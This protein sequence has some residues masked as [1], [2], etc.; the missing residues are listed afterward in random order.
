MSAIPSPTNS[1]HTGVAMA[2]RLSSSWLYAVVCV[3]GVFLRIVPAYGQ[4]NVYPPAPQTESRIANR[5]TDDASVLDPQPGNWVEGEITGN[6]VK[7]Y[8]VA[9]KSNEYLE[10][11]VDQESVDMA[12]AVISGEGRW[13]FE[14]D[15]RE[16]GPEPV[17]LVAEVEGVY[18]LEIR[19][20]RPVSRPEPYK[21]RIKELRQATPQDS[22]RVAAEAAATEGKRLL[23]EGTADFLKQAREKYNS[24]LSLWQV[25]GD[26]LGEADALHSLGHI[27]NILGDSQQALGQLNAALELRRASGDRYGEGETLHNIA[28]A[29]SGWGDKKKAIEYYQQALSLRRSVGD[30]KGEAYDLSNLGVVYRSLGDTR[31]ALAYSTEALPLW[32]ELGDRQG[33]AMV[34]NTLGSTYR[35]MGENQKALDSFRQGLVLSRSVN[36]HRGEAYMLA[37]LSRVYDDLGEGEEA[38]SSYNQAL[39]LM[40]LVGDLRGEADLLADVAGLYDATGE[41][42]EAGDYYRRALALSEVTHDRRA[43]GYVLAGLGRIDQQLGRSAEAI[44]LEHQAL[45]LMQSVGDLRGQAVALKNLGTFYD[46]QGERQQAL[47]FFRQT[48]P[49]WQAVQDKNGECD[50]LFRIARVEQDVGNLEE[51]RTEIEAALGMIESLRTKVVSQELRASYFASKQSLYEFYINLLMRLHRLH[52]SEGFDATA[53]ETNERA[54]ARTLLETLEEAGADIRQGADPLLLEHERGLQQRINAQAQ[55]QTRL[56]SGKYT[57]AQAREAKD[58]LNS[59]LAE[60]REVQAEI[61]VK[62]PRYAALTQPHPLGLREIQ[63]ELL[64]DNTLLLEYSLGEERSFLWAV[65]PSTLRRLRKIT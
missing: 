31:K 52:P 21:L 46:S 54:R 27:S 3:L 41:T 55:S 63:R 2:S 4:S 23:R 29:Y 57:E 58:E 11:I 28:A 40:H 5:S 39:E 17:F 64:D 43:R 18:R 26:H 12:V 61:R 59:L 53:L 65:T 7:S 14:C 15:R 16:V 38:L 45:A 44:D 37:N 48:L 19:V 49:L 47:D 50:A 22:S 25:V 62:S 9:L 56:L 24:A 10:A 20:L 51:A 36:D 13:L 35:L 42:K 32:R 8:R 34:F 6:E 30:H 60:Y 1:A 33:E